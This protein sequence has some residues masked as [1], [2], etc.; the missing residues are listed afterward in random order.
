MEVCK[1]SKACR[2][3]AFFDE[4]YRIQDKNH[5]YGKDGEDGYDNK[6]F[7]EGEGSIPRIRMRWTWEERRS[8]EYDLSIQ[9][10]GNAHKG[11]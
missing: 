2:I 6:E 11:R 4:L 9:Q 7:Y 5:S 1:V 3:P 10:G 8:H